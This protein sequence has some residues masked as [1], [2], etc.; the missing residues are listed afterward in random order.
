MGDI[1]ALRRGSDYSSSVNLAAE[2]APRETYGDG[3]SARYLLL[4][5]EDDGDDEDDDEMVVINGMKR[6]SVQTQTGAAGP[7]RA[8]ELGKAKAVGGE[9]ENTPVA[10]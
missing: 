2:P 6:L 10:A 8:R 1:Q 9:E 7:S 4:D 3:E 5:G